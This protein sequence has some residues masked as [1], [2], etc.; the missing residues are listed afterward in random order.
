[1]DMF[2]GMEKTAPK[3]RG[4]KRRRLSMEQK[5]ALIVRMMEAN[6]AELTALRGVDGWGFNLSQVS[7]MTRY[8]RSTA[9]LNDLLRMCEN[10]DLFFFRRKR[11]ASPLSNFEYWFYTPEQHARAL[12]RSKLI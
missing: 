4:K 5:T 9:L 2:F 10:G 6:A 11:N 12:K 3:K 7:E 1:M 8:E